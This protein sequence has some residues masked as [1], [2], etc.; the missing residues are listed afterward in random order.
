MCI[1]DRAGV[2]ASPVETILGGGTVGSMARIYE[3]APVRDALVRINAVKGDARDKAFIEAANQL[4]AAV[5]AGKQQAFTAGSS[6]AE[7]PNP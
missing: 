6:I 5:Q 7:T 2:I 1:R 3:S 4:Q